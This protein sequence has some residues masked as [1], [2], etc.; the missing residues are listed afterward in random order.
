MALFHDG[1][2]ISLGQSLNRHFLKM[3][4]HSAKDVIILNQSLEVSVN[5]K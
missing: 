4:A 2:T 3:N 1:E 5:V